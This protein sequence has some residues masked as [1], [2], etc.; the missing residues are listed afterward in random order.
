MKRIILAISLIFVLAA[1]SLTSLLFLKKHS[2]N[3]ENKAEYIMKLYEMGNN[4]TAIEYAKE[5][6]QYWEKHSLMLNVLVDTDRISAIN[7]SIYKIE[8][9]IE[10]DSDE[11]IAE[12]ESIMA[13]ARW[14]YECE[15]PMWYNVF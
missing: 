11:L 9:F 2:E 5:F 6:S 12:L 3:I 15:K 10:S 14:L 8:P 13:N 7:S 1:G 4:E